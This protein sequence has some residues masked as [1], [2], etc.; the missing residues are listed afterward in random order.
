[1]NAQEDV[2][3]PSPCS[4]PNAEWAPPSPTP[5]PDC[6]PARLQVNTYDM[7]LKIKEKYHNDLNKH[8]LE[9]GILFGGNRNAADTRVETVVAALRANSRA[10]DSFLKI[11]TV[12]IGETRVNGVA[13]IGMA[14]P[15]G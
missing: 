9:L 7:V 12:L 1:M 15:Q 11:V 6:P 4:L 2:T 14:A 10:A 3:C 13:V 5:L 8:F